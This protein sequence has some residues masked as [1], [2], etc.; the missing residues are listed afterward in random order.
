MGP[1]LLVDYALRFDGVSQNWS[2][3][4]VAN[5]EPAVEQE[6]WGGL[7]EVGEEHLRL[8]DRFEHTPVNYRR[9]LVKVKSPAMGECEAI[10]YMRTGRD[11][12]LPNRSY[13]WEVIKGAV[14]N[15]IPI[16][17]LAQV[18]GRSGLS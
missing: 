13:L 3:T 15:S 18:V 16:E 5:I 4:A 14:E 6:V 9:H 1:A 2:G 12:G 7:Y 17:Y 10:A 11:L 8:L